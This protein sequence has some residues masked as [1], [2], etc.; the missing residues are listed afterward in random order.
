MQKMEGEVSALSFW[1]AVF[2]GDIPALQTIMEGGQ[3]N[4]DALFGEGEGVNVWLEQEG[5][6]AWKGHVG[7]SALMQGGVTP[8]H[9]I[10]TF[11]TGVKMLDRTISGLDHL[12]AV[13]DQL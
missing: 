1:K 7:L 12:T 3:V 6:D 11:A 8:V 2:E 5:R 9:R 4:I 10:H 13:E